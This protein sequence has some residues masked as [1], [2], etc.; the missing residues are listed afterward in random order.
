MGHHSLP[1]CRPN[2]EQTSAIVGTLQ[3]FHWCDVKKLY[4]TIAILTGSAAP[5]KVELQCPT[6]VQI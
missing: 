1:L 3:R 2:D 4:S 5:A 6:G